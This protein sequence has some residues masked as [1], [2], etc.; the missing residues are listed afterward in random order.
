MKR[1]NRV[2]LVGGSWSSN[3]GNAFYNI[4]AEWLLAHLGL[5]V[6]FL[7]ESPRWKAD[8]NELYDLLG[9]T[10]AD[11]FVLVGPCLWQ[12]LSYVYEATF[13]RIYSRGAKVAYLSVGMGTYS[14][15][16]ANSVASF[17]HKFPPLFVS[18]R[19]AVSFNLL[20]PLI[21][22]PIYS[23]LCTSMFLNDALK[24]LPLCRPPYVVFNFDEVEPELMIDTDGVAKVIRERSKRFPLMVGAKEIVRTLNLS[25]DVGYSQIYRRPNSYHSDLPQGYCSLLAFAETVYSERVHTCAT[26]LIFGGQAQ[27]VESSR[28]SLEKRRLLF[29]RL[30][31]KNLFTGPSRLDMN[32]IESEKRAMVRFLGDVLFP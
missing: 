2:A 18:T 19:D 23:G 22:T 10:D 6:S 30:G 8:V 7:P 13:E 3:I 24:P 1:F 25:I 14:D 20:S 26:T 32:Y 21:R 11:L 4:G 27:F 9:D 5:S 16:E 15:A 12:R 31:V 28:R 29:E 17:L